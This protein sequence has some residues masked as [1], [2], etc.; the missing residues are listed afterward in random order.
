MTAK[1]DV[2]LAYKGDDTK[3]MKHFF[4]IAAHIRMRKDNIIKSDDI[5]KT[6]IAITYNIRKLPIVQHHDY[7]K[8]WE[9]IPFLHFVYTVITSPMYTIYRVV[10]SNC[11]LCKF[12][13]T[14]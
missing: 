9:P 12:D 1:V 2:F 10:R 7:F 14:P 8:F 11:P 13:L 3:V 4:A 5:A 6:D